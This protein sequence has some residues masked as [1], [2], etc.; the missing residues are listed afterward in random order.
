MKRDITNNTAGHF[1][2]AD[3]P[4]KCQSENAKVACRNLLVEEWLKDDDLVTGF[5]EAHK[6]TQHSYQDGPQSAA[7]VRYN[8]ENCDIPPSL[9]PVVIETSVSGFKVR[10]KNGE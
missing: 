6:S 8:S 10:P 9:A 3:V 1:N 5:N 4:W 2:V 7:H